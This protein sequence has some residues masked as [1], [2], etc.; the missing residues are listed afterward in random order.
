MIVIRMG[1]SNWDVTVPTEKGPVKFNLKE[2]TKDQRRQFHS[3]FMSAYRSVHKKP[4]R[5][6]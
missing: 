4:K 1:A 6:A 2:M 5:K 3:E